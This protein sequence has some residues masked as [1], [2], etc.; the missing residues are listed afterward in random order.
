MAKFRGK[1]LIVQWIHPGGTALFQSPVNAFDVDGSTDMVEVSSGNTQGKEYIDGPNDATATM[2]FYDDNTASGT[3]LIG[4][5]QDGVQG[6]VYYAPQGTVAGK[7][8]GGFAAII[9]NQKHNIPYDK[10]V[11]LECQ[12]QK[13]G[14]WL[15]RVGTDVWP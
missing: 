7:P 3:A 1:D 2:K 12:W 14:N 11:D 13:T 6:T 10:A 5:T 8:K 15:K 4:A 9:K